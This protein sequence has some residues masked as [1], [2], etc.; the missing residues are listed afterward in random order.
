MSTML[1]VDNMRHSLPQLSVLLLLL[2]HRSLQAGNRCFET[3]PTWRVLLFFGGFTQRTFRCNSDSLQL[4]CDPDF[5]S[6]VLGKWGKASLSSRH[7]FMREAGFGRRS[8][9]VPVL[10]T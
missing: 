8:V 5:V 1:L 7:S 10:P 3:M 4:L 2:R 6:A 9:I